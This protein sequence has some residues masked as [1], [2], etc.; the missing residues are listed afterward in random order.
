MFHILMNHK[1][2]KLRISYAIVCIAAIILY[3]TGYSFTLDFLDYMLAGTIIIYPIVEFIRSSIKLSIKILV[4]VLMAV[5][6]VFIV[7]SLVF[8]NAF[9]ESKRAILNWRVDGYKI[10]LT[11]RQGWAGPPYKQYDL[12]KCRF[13]GLISKTIAHEW[14]SDFDFRED[15]CKIQFSEE[16][17]YNPTAKFT[18]EFD[19]CAKIVKKIKPTSRKDYREKY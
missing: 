3:S 9:G 7:K 14:V 1:T 8:V 5:L 11:K 18:Y 10:I 15:P 19:S 6:V 13:F 17:E 2:Q 12:I 16:E 4:G